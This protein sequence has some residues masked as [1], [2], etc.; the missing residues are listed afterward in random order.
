MKL[1]FLFA[2]LLGG[3]L[4]AS[5]QGD[6]QDGVDN[7]NAGRPDVAKTILENT[8]NNADTKKQVSYY[9]LGS[10]DFQEGNLAGAKAYFEK[11]VQADPTY[12]MNYIGLGEVALKQG[13]KG[14]A[15]NLFKQATQTD[16]KN[17]ALVAEVARAYYNVD[18]V[19]YEKEIAK[20]L[21]KASKDSKRTEAAASILEGDM[22]ADQDPGQA[23]GL[24]EVAI[25][26]SKAKGVV[27]REAYVKYANT[28]FRVAPEFA[29][30]KLEELNQL[31]PNSAL[32]QRELAEKYYSNNQ[33]GSAYQQ[34]G[35]YLQ[36]P[37][38]FQKDER[39]YVQLL[40]AAKEYQQAVD[41]ANAILAQDPTD[42]AMYR[43]ILLSESAQENWAAAET[44]GEKLF[45]MAK[46]DQLVPNDYIVYGQALSEEGKVDQ[47][48]AVYEKAIELNPDKPE[49]LVDLS[50]VY[51]KAGQN[52]KAVETMERYLATGA[53]STN[54]IVKMAQRYSGLARSLEKGTPER[55]EAADKGL[56]YIQQAIDR[57]PDNG[58]L[59]RIKGELLVAKNDNK[60]D[61]AMAEAYEKM[62]S[63]FNADPTNREKYASSYR[64]ADYLLG[65]YYFDVDKVKARQYLNDYLTIMPDD[66]TAK[67]LLKQLGAE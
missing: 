10:I 39:R 65:I 35:K 43:M 29:I 5:A 27:N 11:G 56:A 4:G 64:A 59:Y 46:E 26:Q 63:I 28:Y 44:A 7:Y 60:P 32:A 22:I 6:Y 1:K 40:V 37:N 41:R 50:A 14:E 38:H 36:N 54:D 24:Y 52:D 18:P 25:E 67:A 9:Y 62:L 30:K 58:T 33:W 20:N 13:N 19:K 34:Y 15:E 12:G 17:Y 21:E 51:E 16:K 57:V 3:A 42:Y 8:I 48:V 53:A 49:I 66:E 47:A 31:E 2:L 45:A 61:A 55:A 23:A